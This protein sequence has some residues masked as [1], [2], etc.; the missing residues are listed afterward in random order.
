MAAY[1]DTAERSAHYRTKGLD[2]LAQKVLMTQF[3]DSKQSQD[4]TLSYNCQG[5]GR[6]HHFRRSI[7]GAG[8]PANPLPI[9][10]ASQALG[11]PAQEMMQAQVFQNA[12]CSWRCWYCF[13]D[14]NLLDGNPRH[15]AFLSADELIDLYLAEDKQC[16]IIDLSGGQP[17][18]V[19]EWLLWVVD[20]LRRRGLEHKVYLW[21]DDN[22]SN[23]YLWEALNPD[24]LRRI[25]TYPMYG[26][27]G[28]FKGFDADSFAFNTRANPELFA[29]QF[30]VMRRLVET[31]LDV[32]GYVTLTS[33]NDQYIPRKVAEFVSRL[34]D[35]VHP[36]FPLRTIP[37]PIITFTPTLSRMGEDHHRSVLIQQEVA[38]AWEAE[39]ARR[40]TPQTRSKPVFS[41]SLHK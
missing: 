5:F 29:K 7:P 27:V 6:I 8:F 37:L 31:G 26:R 11:L 1:I 25:A 16:P 22:L 35:E 20:A 19:P 40:F 36:N 38:A 14:Y 2:K 18:L 33:D 24:E 13:V 32:Y 28:C 10:P 34:Q 30:Q 23:D 39:L 3:A 41:H 12:V 4:I 9:D 17:D 21:S 15:S